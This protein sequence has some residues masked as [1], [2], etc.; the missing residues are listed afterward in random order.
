M[1]PSHMAEKFLFRISNI[2]TCPFKSSP[3]LVHNRERVVKGRIPHPRSYHNIDRFQNSLKDKLSL[4]GYWLI[5]QQSAISASG[6]ILLHDSKRDWTMYSVTT[7]TIFGMPESAAKLNMPTIAERAIRVAKSR[8]CQK[9]Y[10]GANRTDDQ[11]PDV[12]SKLAVKVR[13]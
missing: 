13:T 11:S 12:H 10:Y 1:A 9:Y 4:M 6:S 2:Q 8:L 7:V 5:P 3:D